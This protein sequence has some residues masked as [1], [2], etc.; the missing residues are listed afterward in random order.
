[1][2]YKINVSGKFRYLALNS[3]TGLTDLKATFIKPDGS[4]VPVSPV[5]L[6]EVGNGLYEC[7]YTPDVLGEWTLK[8]VGTTTNDKAIKTFKVVDKLEADSYAE[9]LVVD[10]KIDI[11]DGVVD[12]LATDMSDIK[13]TGF[14]ST[15]DSLKAISEKISPGGYI[16]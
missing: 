9:I 1:M 13:G 2:E 14:S 5:I 3:T 10:G 7:S 16:G 8:V 11:I 12:G 6:S 15:T 4:E